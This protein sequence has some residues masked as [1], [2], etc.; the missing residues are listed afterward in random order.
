MTPREHVAELQ[1]RM[2]AS[3]IGQ[4]DVIRQ[5]IIDEISQ[6]RV[7]TRRTRVVGRENGLGP[8]NPT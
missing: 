4:A 3:V 8:L 2:E 5:M 1:R 7:G 6:A